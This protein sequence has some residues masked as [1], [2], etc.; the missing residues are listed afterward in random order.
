M[1]RAALWL[2]AAALL[3]AASI[4][5]DAPASPLDAYVREALAHNP[6]MSAEMQG[7]LAR[8]LE[9][10]AARAQR[11]PSLDLDARYTR[12]TGGR[13]I[14]FPAGQLFNPIYETLNF[15]LEQQGEP[16]MFQPTVQDFEDPIVRRKEQDTRL[17]LTAP[18]YAPEIRAGVDAR[19]AQRALQE[20]SLETTARVLVREV[21][22]AYYGAARAQAAE[23]I[24]QASLELLTE[25][26]RV[27]EVLVR[28]GSATRDRL[29]RARAEQLAAEQRLDAA[30]ARTRQA[31]RR[32]AQLMDRDT[33]E[34]LQLP[35]LDATGMPL[36]TAPDHAGAGMPDTGYRPELAQL[37]HAID[38]TS[39]QSRAAS[40]RL[41]PTLTL[42]ADYGIQGTDYRIDSDAEVGTVSLV[43]RWN[44]FD[45]GQRRATRDAA[46]AETARLRAE[47]R[48]LER[49]LQLARDSAE[50]DTG[51][52][53]RALQTA[54]A[55]LE[56]A[57]A[58]FAIAERK[59]EED[60]L[61]QVEFLDAERA[62]TEAR[63][64]LVVAH[65]DLQDQLAELDFVRAAYP[66][67]ALPIASYTEDRHARPTAVD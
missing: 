21:H 42:A 61:T 20:A 17:R 15:L 54:R 62:L 24:L 50:D 67:P 25:D 1:M 46:D 57:E 29:L 22:R 34:H 41:L 64:G 45:F 6:A 63:L 37:D 38:T 14:G 4:A 47:R 48:D 44:L 27:A 58:S 56:A 39:S 31:Q 53:R 43:M 3:P 26:V 33:P 10:R 49:Q 12:A 40:A 2:L 19:L 36:E 60:A 9:L 23:R 35:A 30:R 16:P 8:E 18:L 7:L 28:E 13:T 32:L 52:V 65:F 59:R 55:R 66:L 11:L 5:A 51:V